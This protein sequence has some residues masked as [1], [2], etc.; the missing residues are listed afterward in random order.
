M[1]ISATSKILFQTFIKVDFSRPEKFLK[2]P[3]FVLHSQWV[4]TDVFSD[5]AL[6][7]SNI[8][9]RGIRFENLPRGPIQS[10]KA[11]K[12]RNKTNQLLQNVWESVTKVPDQSNVSRPLLPNCKAV[13]ASQLGYCFLNC[14]TQIFQSVLFRLKM[15]YTKKV[16]KKDRRFKKEKTFSF[17]AF[18]L[19]QVV[20][21]WSAK[22]N[23]SAEEIKQGGKQKTL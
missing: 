15:S 10:E 7:L 19:F 2:Q 3:S 23:F 14:K 20:P 16:K 1:S 21:S 13:P 8:V 4:C 18:C 6:S 12:E 11:E 9:S 22:S 5:K 17:L